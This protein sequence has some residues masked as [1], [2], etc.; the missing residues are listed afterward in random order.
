MDSLDPS[1]PAPDKLRVEAPEA[2][3]P[4]RSGLKTRV[5]ERVRADS[6]DRGKLT[7]EPDVTALVPELQPAELRELL[8]E[9]GSDASHE[10]IKAIVA[11]EGRVYLYSERHLAMIEAQDRAHEEEAKLAIADRIRADSSRIV[12]TAAADLEPLVPFEEPGRRAAFFEELRADPRF[13]DVQVVTGPNG[14][15]SYR[16]DRFL[17]G[18][19]GTIMMRAQANQPCGTVA[20]LVRDRSRLM[21]APT[22]L[23]TFHDPVFRIDPASLDGVVE[24]LFRREEFADV[25]KVVHPRTRAVYLYS[26]QFL[27]EKQAVWM[28]DWEEVGRLRNP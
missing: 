6:R 24:E 11:P 21:P 5:A 15:I 9:M 8:H 18:N 4:D 3:A 16:S 27:D 26:D 19:Y 25:K 20:E 12:L 17:S 13:E 28:V 1:L 2:P 14:E 10:D 23:E 7:A 22:K